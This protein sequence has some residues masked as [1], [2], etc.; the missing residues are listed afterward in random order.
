MKTTTTSTLLLLGVCLSLA[1][2]S[3]CSDPA[4]ERTPPSP[5]DFKKMREAAMA[6][7][8]MG[9]GQGGGGGKQ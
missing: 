2:L 6:G 3:G 7:G 4:A 8:G 9:G 5:E 1:Y